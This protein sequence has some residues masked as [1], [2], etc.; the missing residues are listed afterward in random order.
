LFIVDIVQS[1]LTI[2]DFCSIDNY[3][4]VL[5]FGCLLPSYELKSVG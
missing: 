4:S 3:T 2:I 1:C 5:G